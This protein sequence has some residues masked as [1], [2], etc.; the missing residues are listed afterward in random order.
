MRS[1]PAWKAA[2]AASPSAVVAARRDQRRRLAA[3]HLDREAGPG[4]H[5]DAGAR[6]G[7]LG[8]LVAEPA[9]AFL[10][11]L[12][13]PEH[14]R[15]PAV[16]EAAQHRVEARHRR[17][18]HDQPAPRHGAPP[19]RSRSS[20]AA[21]AAG[22]SRAGSGR[23]GASDRIAAACAASRAHRRVGCDAAAWTASAVPHAPAPSTVRFI[24]AASRRRLSLRCSR[25]PE[26]LVALATWVCAS[27]CCA[28]NIA[29]KLTSESITGGKPARVQTSE[30]MARRYGIDDPRAVDAEDLLQRSLGDVADLED[31]ALLGL[32]QEHHL[33]V[34]LGRDRRGHRHLVGRLGHDLGAEPEVDLDLRLA[35]LEQDLRRVRLLERQVLQVDPLDRN[36]GALAVSSAMGSSLEEGSG[37][38]RARAGRL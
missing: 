17:G 26:P 7:R 21:T 32:D 6:H 8:D 36:R 18:D 13:Q 35:L 11:A 3:R 1:D 34:D 20:P 23:C 16:A 25:A 37:G 22:R 33:V 28:S 9:G 5:A 2:T 19:R 4:E 24:G 31:A 38:R 14:R 29:W 30:T 12:A 15:V 10:E 27:A